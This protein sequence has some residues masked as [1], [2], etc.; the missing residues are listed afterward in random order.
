MDGLAG[1]ADLTV[2]LD[3]AVVHADTGGGDLAAQL[4][5]Q[6]TQGIV[7]LGAAHAA[8]AGDQD[9][10]VGDVDGLLGL[11]GH[12]QDLHVHVVHGQAGVHHDDLALAV[13]V[14]L[15][16]LHHA[17]TDGGHLRTVVPAHDGGHDVAAEGGTGHLQVPVGGVQSGNLLL[18]E[19]GGLAQVLLIL[20]HVHV[21]AGAVGGQAGV[22]AAGDPGRHV[23]AD[24]AGAEEHHV[25]IVVLDDVLDAADIGLGGVVL[26][27][28]SVDHQHLL[29]A[30]L[31]QGLG[32]VGDLVAHENGDNLLTQVGGQLGGLGDQLIADLLDAAVALFNNNINIFTHRLFASLR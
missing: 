23:T 9:L 4:G 25:G 32:L 29:S 12:V 6:L 22:H 3:P 10:G 13:G 24:A 20:G 5:S 14:L 11:L 21:Q 26:Q 7:A 1:L 15:A 31:D 19:V 16:Q 2:L 18:G 27:H 8:A 28:G 30:I 17:G